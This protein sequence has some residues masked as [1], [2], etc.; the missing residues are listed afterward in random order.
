MASPSPPNREIQVLK[1][2]EAAAIKIGQLFASVNKTLECCFEPEGLVFADN[3][4]LFEAVTKVNPKK[5]E[6]R[7]ITEITENNMS[8][9]RELMRHMNV[10]HLAGI[11]G[12]FIIVDGR[13][14]HHITEEEKEGEQGSFHMLSVDDEPFVSTQQFLFRNLLHQAMPAKDRIAE[15]EKGVKSEFIETIRQPAE[16][17]K[18]AFDLMQMASFEIL[19][20]FPTVNTFY[21]AEM[22]GIVKELGEASKRGV[23][24]RVLV[25]V[26][27]DSMKDASKQKIKE[28]HEEINVE[29]MHQAIRTRITT[30]I[31]DEVFSL[32]LEVNDDS[33][34]S[35]LDATGISTYSNSESTVL[36]YTSMF[37]SLWIQADMARQGKIKQAYFQIFKGQKLRDEI[38]ERKWS[39]EDSPSD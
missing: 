23:K 18:I 7:I 25:R 9:C 20:L 3:S 31:V 32:A 19:A 1:G 36:T 35:F 22:D 24:V 5:L 30:F 21:R 28:K 33:T 4:L 11:K 26:D 15:I 10:Y 16:A 27:S 14:F 39:S 17:I 8:R 13:R 6:T 34:N 38:Y 2:I 12:N 37:E 29:F